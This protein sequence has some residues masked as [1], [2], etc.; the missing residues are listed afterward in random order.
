MRFLRSFLA[1]VVLLGCAFSAVATMVDSDLGNDYIDG[2]FTQGLIDYYVGVYGSFSQSALGKDHHAYWQAMDENDFHM[3]QTNE[4]KEQTF[5]GELTFNFADD[6]RA[7]VG[8]RAFSNELTAGVVQEV[9]TFPAGD[10][11]SLETKKE[12]DVIGK[13][14][15]SYDLSDNQMLYGTISEGYR[16]G[17]ANGYPTVGFYGSEDT[18][19][20]YDSDK[21]T[22]FELG[23][24]GSTDSMRYTVALFHEQWDKPQI[25]TVAVESGVYIV[26][27]GDKA[28]TEGLEME[29]Q[30]Y[31]TENLDISLGYAYVTAELTAD[32]YRADG[33]LVA[34]SGNKLP[35]VAEHSANVALNYNVPMDNGM[36]M[37]YRVSGFYQ[38]ET[39]NSINNASELYG[40]TFDAFSIWEAAA[41][42]SNDTWTASLYA[43]NLLNEEGT[44]AAF[45]EEHMGSNENRNYGGNNSSH[46][47]ISTPRTIGMSLNYIF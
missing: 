1:F 35:G 19:L 16:R 44:T 3:V 15:L 37:D 40:T 10:G 26:Q 34:T 30:A 21:V 33:S 8:A 45:K 5:Y 18:M 41:T 12:D 36:T 11:N 25:N 38:S 39:E 28:E 17:G 2:V 43:K 47:Y 4:F 42:L 23:L 7:T 24:K 14:N 27:N 32:F 9:R 6:F 13:L 29:V 46:N 20:T 22:N 31:L